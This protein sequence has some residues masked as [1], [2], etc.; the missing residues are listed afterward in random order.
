MCCVAEWADHSVHFPAASL[1]VAVPV[2]MY[3]VLRTAVRALHIV[4]CSMEQCDHSVQVTANGILSS[5]AIA[6]VRFFAVLH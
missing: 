6:V 4:H 1:I 5:Y 3:N 2:I